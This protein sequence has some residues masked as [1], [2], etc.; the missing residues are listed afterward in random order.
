[1]QKNGINRINQM[2]HY[3]SSGCWWL[4]AKRFASHQEGL[5]SIPSYWMASADLACFSN[6]S[7]GCL[8]RLKFGGTTFELFEPLCAA[9]CDAVDVLIPFF[10]G[11]HCFF[12]QVVLHWLSCWIESGRMA[13]GL[14]GHG[15]EA[16]GAHNLAISLL[17]YNW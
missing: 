4:S 5:C 11:T 13:F 7:H 14:C 17:V 3:E 2:T 9:G 10:G 15:L 1:M 16:L 12:Q 8:I 6:T